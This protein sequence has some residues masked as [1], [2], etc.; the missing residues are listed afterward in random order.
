VGSSKGI[1]Q[2]F[3]NFL[4]GDVVDPSL[5]EQVVSPM[6]AAKRI[7]EPR[8]TLLRLIRVGVHGVTTGYDSRPIFDL[9]ERQF[10]PYPLLERTAQNDG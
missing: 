5:Q 3:Y 10:A 2:T 7:F 9:P 4:L 1:T 6:P 8:F